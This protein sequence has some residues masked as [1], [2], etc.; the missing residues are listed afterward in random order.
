MP[1]VLGG[2]KYKKGKKIQKKPEEEII[3]RKL[4]FKSKDQEYAVVVR[5]LGNKRVL[6]LTNDNKEII[7]RISPKFK[8]MKIWIQ[9]DDLVLISMRDNEDDKSDIIYKYTNIETK[10]LI[11]K[12]QLGICILEKFNENKD[13]DDIEFLEENEEEEIPLVF[14]ETDI[15]DL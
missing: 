8:R 6:V 12:D 14:K 13:D 9:L 15:D 7:S 5:L 1:N 11:E 4:E 3:Q 10:K 2:S